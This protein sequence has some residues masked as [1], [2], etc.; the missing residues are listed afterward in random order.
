M[1]NPYGNN[2]IR[3]R[4]RRGDEFERLILNT[5][6]DLKATKRNTSITVDYTRKV[7][8][9]TYDISSNDSALIE[10]YLR[11]ITIKN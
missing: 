6:W 2:T 10:E 5:F 3:I 7:M 9:S 8:T 1:Y 4:T 11:R